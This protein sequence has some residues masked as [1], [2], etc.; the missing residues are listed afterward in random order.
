MNCDFTEKVSLLIDGEL[1]AADAR[2]VERHLLACFECQQ[3]RMDFLNL[4]SQMAAYE[5]TLSPGE[6]R[7]ALANVLAKQ[8]ATTARHRPEDH[9]AGIVSGRRLTWGFSPRW[10][11]IAGLVVASLLALAVYHNSQRVRGLP[12]PQATVKG[13]EP[14][15]P[16]PTMDRPTSPNPAKSP[17]VADNRQ[18]NSER[19]AAPRITGPGK[20]VVKRHPAETLLAQR[21]EVSVIDL[22]P[23]DDSRKSGPPQVRSADAETMT[24]VHFEKSELLLRAFR[25]VRLSS[26][27]E[28]AEIDYERQRAQQLI[29]QNIMLRREADTAG[30]VQVATL[31][32]SL[33]PILLD[34]ANLPQ[35]PKDEDVRAIQQRV[36]RKNIVA[37]LQVNSTALAGA[38]D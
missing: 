2:L 22:G 16:M 38:L 12:A 4:R 19:L 3:A 5:M 7:E 24:A 28:A 31:L 26:D 29:Y 33:E 14:G 17:A 15:S 11:A 30:D 34:I 1:P 9:R 6:Q 37:L 13:P 18:Q 8:D 21:N 35:H 27:G 23:Q 20:L 32:E 10:V 36:E 25:N